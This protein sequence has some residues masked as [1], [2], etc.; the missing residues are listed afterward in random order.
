[1][2]GLGLVVV[3]VGLYVFDWLEKRELDVQEAQAHLKKI[4]DD[5][6]K[7]LEAE[8]EAMRQQLLEHEEELQD[9]RA[10]LS[11]SGDVPDS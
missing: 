1:M 10:R 11:E 4:E 6:R 8:A 7:R 9:L 5:R 3:L 2:T